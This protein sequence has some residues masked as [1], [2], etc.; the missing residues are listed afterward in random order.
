MGDDPAAFRLQNRETMVPMSDRL[1]WQR[2]HVVLSGEPASKLPSALLGG[3]PL[4]LRPLP[5]GDSLADRGSSRRAAKL[6][7]CLILNVANVV[8]E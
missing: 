8:S 7:W 1:V 4:P 2:P 6:R 3:C 5:Q